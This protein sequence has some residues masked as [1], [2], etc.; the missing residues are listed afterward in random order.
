[1]E[2][3]DFSRCNFWVQVHNLPPNRMN[4]ETAM[5][6]GNYV[7][8]YIRCDEG[9]N[10]FVP[11]KFIRLQ[12]SVNIQNGLKVGCYITS[13]NGCKLWIAFKYERIINFCYGCGVI[14]HTEQACSQ[15]KKSYLSPEIEQQSFSPWMSATYQRFQ[16]A[17][18]EEQAKTIDL[19]PEKTRWF[20][21]LTQFLPTVQKP[22]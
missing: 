20:Q 9:T 6:L 4:R 2:E 8:K 11:N 3:I 21:L 14:D 1:M 7:G 15:E 18:K 13:E 5:I 22:P 10:S 12:V 19:K 17:R 16:S